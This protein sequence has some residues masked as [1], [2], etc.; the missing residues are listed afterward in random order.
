MTVKECASLQ[1]MEDLVKTISK[2]NYPL[3]RN[4]TLEALGNAVNVN[5]VESIARNL[6]KI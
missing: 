6:L 3:T 2:N 4:R 1:G 5:I